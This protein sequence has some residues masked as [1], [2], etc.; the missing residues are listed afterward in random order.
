MYE[1]NIASAVY[2]VRVEYSL[3]HH[4]T[5]SG[6]GGHVSA[7]PDFVKSCIPDFNQNVY[8]P[9]QTDQLTSLSPFTPTSTRESLY[10]LF[11]N[12]ACSG[13]PLH[14]L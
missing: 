11:A 12:V 13:A 5:H 10:S 1:Y 2:H 9:A 7:F 3:S 14:I 6:R 8:K 4:A